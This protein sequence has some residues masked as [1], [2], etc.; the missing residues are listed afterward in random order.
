MNGRDGTHP[1]G[2]HSCSL[3]V[4][5]LCMQCTIEFAENIFVSFRLV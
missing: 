3:V 5:Y 4:S 2:M 1:T